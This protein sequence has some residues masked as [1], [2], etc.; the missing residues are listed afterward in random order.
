M[1]ALPPPP[2]FL[3][4]WPGGVIHFLS[5]SDLSFL[6]ELHAHDGDITALAWAPRR[7]AWQGRQVGVLAT[8]SGD[9]RVRLW[10]SPLD[11]E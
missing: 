1:L 4:A 11:A 3:R 2:R 9:R 10:H 6:G 8:S 5:G 7:L